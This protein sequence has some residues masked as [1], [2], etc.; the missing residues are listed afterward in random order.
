MWTK[1]GDKEARRV[2]KYIPFVALLHQL[3]A[4]FT[5]QNEGKKA[6][7][8]DVRR[9][10][11]SHRWQPDEENFLEANMN[12][13]RAMKAFTPN[14]LTQKVYEDS[15][16][17]TLTTEGG[18][19]WICV[20]ALN[21]F[22]AANNR[23]PVSNDIPDMQ[24][25]T[26]EYQTLKSIFKNRADADLADIHS[27]VQEFCTSL[28]VAKDDAYVTRF[29][30]N[31]RFIRAQRTTPIENEY[32]TETFNSAAI[33]DAIEDFDWSFEKEVR[34]L[35]YNW[36]YAFRAG[37]AFKRLNG[38]TAGTEDTELK[39]DVKALTQIGLQLKADHKVPELDERVFFEVVR[40]AGTEPHNT[41]AIVGGIASQV[42]LKALLHQFVIVDNTIIVNAIHGT[43]STLSL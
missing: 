7:S 30:K 25:F 2:H 29:I 3:Y 5:A 36:Y 34:P 43:V 17:R 38:R 31:C 22:R 20:R 8:A 21:D 10:I 1:K 39:N 41:A 15:K 16:A 35:D 32:L 27:R 42:M 18:L 12:V 6:T 13:I 11:N 33:E 28:S 9:F 14:R 26:Q 37:E 40:Y 23:L 19:F 4:K 24:S